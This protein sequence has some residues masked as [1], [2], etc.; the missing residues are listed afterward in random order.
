MQS[1]RSAFEPDDEGNVIETPLV[2][3]P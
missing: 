1:V 2:C 3:D